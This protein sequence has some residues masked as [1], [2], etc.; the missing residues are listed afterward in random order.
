MGSFTRLQVHSIAGLIA[1]ITSL[2]SI[3]VAHDRG[4]PDP[5]NCNVAFVQSVVSDATLVQAATLE[6]EPVEHCNVV[7]T[8]T[9]DDPGPNEVNLSTLDAD[10]R[11]IDDSILQGLGGTAGGLPGSFAGTARTRLCRGSDRYRQPDGWSRWLARGRLAIHAVDEAQALDH[12]R[13]AGHLR[14]SKRRQSRARTTGGG[15][16]GGYHSMLRWWPNGDQRRRRASRRLRRHRAR[17]ARPDPG[18]RPALRRSSSR[19]TSISASNP[20]R[21]ST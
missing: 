20:V 12:D 15:S 6:S 16:S 5:A 19:T 8:I 17:R 2:P 1:L 10:L 13:R 21:S 4:R 18:Q 11:I 9:T 7:A 14:R 3:A